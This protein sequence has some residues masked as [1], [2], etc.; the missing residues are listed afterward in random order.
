MLFLSGLL[1]CSVEVRGQVVE[2]SGAP[3]AGAVLDAEGACGAVS[4]AD[5]T[6]RAR[7][8]RADYHFLVT[9]P[10]HAAG[11][12]HV[13]ASGALPP[14]PA[15]ATLTPWPDTPGVYVEP[16]YTRLPDVGLVRKADKTE[17]RFCVPDGASFAEVGAGA[18]LFDVHAADWRVYPLDAE[19]CALRLTQPAGSRFWSPTGAPVSAGQA[20]EVAPGRFRTRLTLP[21]GRYVLVPWLDGFFVPDDVD[22]DTW[23]AAGFTVK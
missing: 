17:T 3:V 9:H 16:A 5:G 23:F 15:T 18:S 21:A 6:F 12:L 4:A 14:E 19:G 7:C 2:P 20:E 10:T 8:R 13:D 11:T 22:K 1:G